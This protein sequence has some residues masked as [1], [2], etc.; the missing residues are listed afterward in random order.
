MGRYLSFSD[1]RVLVLLRAE[2]QTA[3]NAHPLW[4]QMPEELSYDPDVSALKEEIKDL[5]QA[6]V[7]THKSNEEVKAIN[8]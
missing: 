5:Q 6:F 2:L 4:S 8:K 3:A 1:V 7:E